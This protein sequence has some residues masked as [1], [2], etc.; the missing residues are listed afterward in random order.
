MRKLVPVLVAL[1]LTAC[2]QTT[3]TPPAHHTPAIHLG[4]LLGKAAYAVDIPDDWNGTLFL[5]SHGYVAPGGYNQAQEGPPGDAQGWLLVHH[6]AVAGSG[7]SS[8]GWALE[9]AFKDQIALL[10]FITQRVGKP[11]RVVAWGESLGGIITAGLLQLYP[12]RFAAAMPMCGVLSGAIATWNTEL[13]AAYAFKT[14]LGPSSA[15]RIVHVGDGAANL[16]LAES[17]FNAATQTP[18]GRARLALV[19][20]LIDLPGWFDPTKIEPIAAD[21]ADRLLAQERWE[22]LVDFP[23]AFQYRTELEARAGGNPSWN[24]GVHYGDLLANSPSR[25]E[26]TALYRLSGLDLNVDLT[27]LDTGATIKPDPAAAQYLARYIAFDGK[28]AVPVL[29]MHTTG[30]GLVIP[31]NESAYAQVVGDA[32]GQDLLR[33]VFVHRAGHCAFTGAET[34]AALQALLKRLDGGRWDDIALKPEALNAAA[35]KLG[36][37]ESTI[38]G[39]TFDPAYVTYK[40]APYPRPFNAGATIPT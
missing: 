8:S 24:V 25:D 35:G 26:V 9:D 16:Q 28:L 10:D 17:I 1:L 31:P 32:G 34:I 40:P 37:H 11:K 3:G 4:G 36:A 14:L 33:Q 39:F 22:S 13:D 2:N 29:S 15:L 7:Y 20:A 12:D 21:Y 27:T 19:A 5:Y 18:Q 23:F 6:Y 38:F 30:D